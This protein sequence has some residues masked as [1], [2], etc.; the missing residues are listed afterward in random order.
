M[1]AA[2]K[3]P[4]QIFTCSSLRYAQELKLT[5]ADLEKTGKIR[6]VE[7]RTPKSWEK[8]AVHLIDP[9]VTFSP[10]RGKLL[11]VSVTKIGKIVRAQIDW[12]NLT[13]FVTTFGDCPAPLDY[14]WYGEKGFVTK[15]IKETFSAFKKSIL[16]FVKALEKEMK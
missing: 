10:E 8:Y 14:T 13:A 6:F 2:Q 3:Y 11:D 12:E 4:G 15:A 7:A 16:E 1:F 9:I 5:N